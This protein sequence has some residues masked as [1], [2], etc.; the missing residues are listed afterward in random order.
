MNMPGVGFVISPTMRRSIIGFIQ[1]SGRVATL[2]VRT[3]GGKVAI[4]NAY[5]PHSGKPYDER[6]D[7]YPDLS[8]VYSSTSAHGMEMVCG[9]LNARLHRRLGGEEDVLGPFVFGNAGAHL[10][11]GSNRDLLM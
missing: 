7:F 8:R 3:I 11:E 9:D 6:H 5:A 4:I 1:H 10:E 2:K